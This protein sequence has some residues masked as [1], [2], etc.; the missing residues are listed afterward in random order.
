MVVNIIVGICITAL[1]V[2]LFYGI[3]MAIWGVYDEFY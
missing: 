3:Y 2:G 1:V